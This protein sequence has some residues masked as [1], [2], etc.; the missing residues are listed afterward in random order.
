MT[1]TCLILGA[2]FPISVSEYN[3]GIGWWLHMKRFNSIL[4]VIIVVPAQ[5]GGGAAKKGTAQLFR[6]ANLARIFINSSWYDITKVVINVYDVAN[7]PLSFY[8]SLSLSLFL[9]FYLPLSL[10]PSPS[11]QDTYLLIH[12]IR[13]LIITIDIH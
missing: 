13:N 7:S 10:S 6:L 12:W 5:I 4:G 8:L 2:L 9:S 1:S 11:F 3:S